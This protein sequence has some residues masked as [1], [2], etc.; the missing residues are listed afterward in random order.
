MREMANKPHVAAMA[1]TLSKA[2]PFGFVR[3]REEGKTPN[4]ESRIE[5][6]KP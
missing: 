2:F 4:P 6:P 1:G 5:K 3:N